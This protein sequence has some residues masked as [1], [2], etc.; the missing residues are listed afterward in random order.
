MDADVGEGGQQCLDCNP[1][2]DFCQNSCRNG[3]YN[4]FDTCA[5][6]PQCPYA[7]FD[8]TNCPANPNTTGYDR[9][10]CCVLF[11]RVLD[12]A[13][14]VVEE[15]SKDGRAAEFSIVG[16]STTAFYQNSDGSQ[17]GDI[18]SPTT[19]MDQTNA[20]A[21]IENTDYVGGQTN[22]EGAIQYW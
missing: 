20:L 4:I 16:F 3:S 14:G 1:D 2:N 8:A 17:E 12:V 10:T 21:T 9:N 15:V 22:H 6:P 5:F 19:M 18:N 11:R 13:R 7:G